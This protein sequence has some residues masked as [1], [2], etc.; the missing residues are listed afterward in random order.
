MIFLS[1]GGRFF[2]G[3]IAVPHPDADDD[4]DDTTTKC[5]QRP[6]KKY[7]PNERGEP[8]QENV[9]VIGLSDGSIRTTH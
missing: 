2:H 3:L 9:V 8:T 6:T 5:D 4:G 1:F 7:R